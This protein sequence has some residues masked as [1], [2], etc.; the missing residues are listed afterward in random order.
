MASRWRGCGSN[1]CDFSK[2]GV[3]IGAYMHMFSDAA[4]E[5]TAFEFN[6]DTPAA[7]TETPDSVIIG[8]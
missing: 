2:N 4:A 6:F 8:L 1:D 3:N 5:Y 7:L